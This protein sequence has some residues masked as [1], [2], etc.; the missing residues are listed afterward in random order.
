VVLSAYLKLSQSLKGFESSV[1]L[2][3]EIENSK[4]TKE[5]E[6]PSSGPNPIASAHP[7]LDPR[8]QRFNCA[9]GRRQS[10]PPVS[11]PIYE[12]QSLV[13]ALWGRVVRS[14]IFL[15]WRCSG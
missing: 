2:Q 1:N 7:P 10:G 3:I 5:K 14:P 11:S 13:V 9:S 8:G 4:K 15:A 6:K 12:R